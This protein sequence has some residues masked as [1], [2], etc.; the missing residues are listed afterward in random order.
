MTNRIPFG[1]ERP[2]FGQFVRQVIPLR[3]QELEPCL[4]RGIRTGRRVGEVLR[5]RGLVS[6]EQM[7]RV[8]RSQARWVANAT[9]ADLDPDS[10]PYPMSF[11]LCLPAYNE[12]GNIVDTLD[13]ACAILPEFVQEYEI[14]VV[15]DG[16]TDRTRDL[17]SQYSLDEP[18][19]RLLRHEKNR[20]YGAAVT[21][22][23][24]AAQKDLVAFTD[25]DGQFSLLDLPQLLIRMN[26]NDLVIG[27]RY[28]RAD[29]W[30]RRLNAW[31]WG[32]LVWAFLGVLVRDL[33]CAFKVFRRPVVGAMRLTSSGA[34]INAEIMAQCILGGLRYEE[35]PVLHYPRHHGA[36]TGAN[37]R[38]ILRAFHEL[39]RLRKYRHSELL[40]NIGTASM[41]RAK[42]LQ[43]GVRS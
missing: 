35:T 3:R 39:P 40:K 33:D 22:G 15:D 31:G 27:Y 19:V 12:E 10:F 4:E 2:L 38:V 6:R 29:P 23:L 9:A 1:L 5:N 41:E 30:P 21:S 7:K 13:A 20:G 24:R 42:T 16:S 34:G 8:F 32:R 17:V 25:S 37:L 26:D 18:R 28:Q 43:Q 36:S 14:V 11:S